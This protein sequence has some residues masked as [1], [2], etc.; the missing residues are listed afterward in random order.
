MKMLRRTAVLL[1]AFGVVG[2]CASTEVTER[3]RY[4]GAKLA[5][6]DRI[7][8]YDFTAN[9]GD[10]PPESALAGHMA[11]APNPTQQQLE[12]GRKLGAEVAQELVADLQGMGL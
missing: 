3:E 1:L 7:I 4:Q 11:G 9:P 12:V 8:V 10:V 5:R 6:P 2:G